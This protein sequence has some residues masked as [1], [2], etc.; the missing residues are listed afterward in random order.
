M[1]AQGDE[2][3]THYRI[4]AHLLGLGLLELVLLFLLG[5]IELHEASLLPHAHAVYSLFHL[6]GI[7]LIFLVLLNALRL[8]YG[9]AEGSHLPRRRE[10]RGW[11]GEEEA[12]RGG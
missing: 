6:L 10:I 9:L 11:S 5:G 12:A 3:F 1:L 7:M 8:L 2:V 4:A